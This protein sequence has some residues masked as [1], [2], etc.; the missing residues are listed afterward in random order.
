M[1][2]YKELSLTFRENAI[3]VLT[4]TVMVVTVAL[5]SMVSRRTVPGFTII[6]VTAF[7]HIQGAPVVAFAMV[8][9]YHQEQEVLTANILRQK[10]SE[11]KKKIKEK[12]L[13]KL[14][15]K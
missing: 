3:H 12:K 2:G 8:V 14:Y 10:N 6:Q 7:V 15:H 1:N 11:K 4:F 9:I 5:A 13:S